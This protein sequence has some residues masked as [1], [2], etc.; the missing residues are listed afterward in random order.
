[1]LKRFTDWLESRIDVF[2]PFDDR[3]TPPASLKGFAAFYLREVRGWLGVVLL[4]ALL[5]PPSS[6]SSSSASAASSTC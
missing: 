1:M 4:S 5:L 6:R 3:R 2:A